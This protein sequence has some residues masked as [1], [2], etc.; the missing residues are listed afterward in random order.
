MLLDDAAAAGTDPPVVDLLLEDP[1][2]ESFDW[3]SGAGNVVPGQ[4]FAKFAE[5]D[6]EALIEHLG[7]L[8]FQ[9][10]SVSVLH[11]KDDALEISVQSDEA[12]EWISSFAEPDTW[13]TVLDGDIHGYEG[14]FFE[15]RDETGAPVYISVSAL[16]AGVGGVW[17]SPKF[18]DLL[19]VGLPTG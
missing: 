3:G 19:P 11:P 5:T 1:T 8:G 2:G 18:A 7:N 10:V 6:R 17:A 13:T 9:E 16:R 12:A 15:L 4:R 14:V